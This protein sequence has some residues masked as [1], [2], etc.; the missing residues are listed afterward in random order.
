MGGAANGIAYHGGFVPYA[1]TFL[2][3]SDYMRGSIRLAALSGIHVIYVWTHDS[4]GLGEDGPTHQPV[5][6]YAALRAMP[7]LWFIR[8]GDANE[9]SAAWGV[10]AQRRGGPVGLSLT[11]QKLPTLPGT[12]EK[13]REG[14]ARGGYVLADTAKPHAV[15]IATGSE[16][17]LAMDAQRALAQGGIAVRV[18]SMPCTQVFDRQDEAYRVSVLPRGIPRVAIEAGVTDYWRKYVGLEGAVIGIDTFGESAP[19][20]VLF[21]HFGFTVER[22]VGAVKHIIAAPSGEHA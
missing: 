21:K 15:I 2:T 8:P 6:H 19:G 9:T 3:F 4:V 7:N 14:V 13:A 22:V 1:G 5:E 11:R 16:V 17:G 18:V 10:A 12:A 20:P